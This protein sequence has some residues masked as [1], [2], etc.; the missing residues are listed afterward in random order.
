MFA[1]PEALHLRPSCVP[2][3][4]RVRRD[5]ASGLYGVPSVLDVRRSPIS[6][7]DALDTTIEL[8]SNT[9]ASY[10]R[11][12]HVASRASSSRTERPSIDREPAH[13]RRQ[14]HRDQHRLLFG[15]PTHQPTPTGKSQS[16]PTRYAHQPTVSGVRRDLVLLGVRCPGGAVHIADPFHLD[17]LRGATNRLAA[18]RTG[19]P[20]SATGDDGRPQS[21]RRSGCADTLRWG[22]DLRTRSAVPQGVPSKRGSVPQCHCRCSTSQ[23]S[24]AAPRPRAKLCRTGQNCRTCSL[25]SSTGRTHR[26]GADQVG[27]EVRGVEHGLWHRGRDRSH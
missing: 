19:G 4:A 22:S 25:G 7:R 26:C 9:S 10:V 14:R 5:G 15:S 8:T 24:R 11:R 23:S 2:P 6:S 21:S 1:S 12:A 17:R 20:G 13:V 3:A 18:V 16:G 27:N